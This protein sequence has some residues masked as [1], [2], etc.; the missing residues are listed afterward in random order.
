MGA[1]LDCA[2]VL[3]FRDAIYDWF[4]SRLR[5]TGCGAGTGPIWFDNLQVHGAHPTVRRGADLYSGDDHH[6]HA[7]HSHSD[8]DGSA[9]VSIVRKLYLDCVA[10]GASSA[11]ANRGVI[12]CISPLTNFS[13]A[14][15]RSC[16]ARRLARF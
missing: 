14:R 6:A 7:R 4:W 1:H 15:L 2:A 12:A 3:F 9:H 5:I 11:E 13:L 16:L 8:R 10:D